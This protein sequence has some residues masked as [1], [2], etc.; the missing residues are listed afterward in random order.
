MS[1][2]YQPPEVW[3]W[4]KDEVSKFSNIN[5][6]VAGPTHEKRCRWVNTRFSFILLVRRTARK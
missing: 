4:N 1:E 5:R 3:T 2:Q 6:P